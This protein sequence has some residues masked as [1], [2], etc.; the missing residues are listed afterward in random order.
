VT[1]T[2]T[3]AAQ[4]YT[5]GATLSFAWPAFTIVPASCFALSNLLF[6]D[7]SNADMVTD[8]RI[9][10][11]WVSKTISYM[12]SVNSYDPTITMKGVF[13]SPTD[14]TETTGTTITLTGSCFATGI[15]TGLASTSASPTVATST[16]QIKYTQPN[17]QTVYSFPLNT[18]SA[19]TAKNNITYCG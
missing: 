16:Y 18:D 1:Q 5:K 17:L 12:N 2:V 15:I 13:S 4:D 9:A 3:Y 6:T 19:G 8:G 10:I 14:Y 11:N 7:S